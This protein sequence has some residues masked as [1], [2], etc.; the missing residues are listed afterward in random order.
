M[1][2]KQFQGFEY[3]IIDSKQCFVR[4]YHSA[5]PKEELI[6]PERIEGFPVTKVS[7][8]SFVDTGN[9]VDID[10]PKNIVA[11]RAIRKVFLPDS[12]KEVVPASYYYGCNVESINVP[13]SI[14]LDQIEML[15]LPC[16]QHFFVSNNNQN[17]KTKDGV[18]FSGDGKELICYPKGS[19]R[20][21]YEIP[22]ET[23]IIGKRAFLMRD[24]KDHWYKSSLKEIIIPA[25]VKKI[26]TEAICFC[27]AKLKIPDN[28]IDYLG[29]KALFHLENTTKSSLYFKHMSSYTGGAFN[30]SRKDMERVSFPTKC[31]I[32]YRPDV[33]YREYLY[34][35]IMK[36]IKAS[37]NKKGISYSFA[38]SPMWWGGKTA[39]HFFD[40]IIT[41]DDPVLFESII[42]DGTFKQIGNV[43]IE[44]NKIRYKFKS[45]PEKL[46]YGQRTYKIYLDGFAKIKDTIDYVMKAK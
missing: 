45:N 11:R 14:P 37:K 38:Y 33:D 44:D 29:R 25:S 46:N 18:L 17:Y 15:N 16:V 34:F 35:N 10:I 7:L 12:V 2:K 26:E 21:T 5:V 6:I 23:E 42:N 19:Q 3:E 4:G 27:E 41:V 9:Y 39:K 1:G 13:E 22:A 28:H 40:T 31:S 30:I 32:E 8:T 20:A 36:R 24:D 43:V